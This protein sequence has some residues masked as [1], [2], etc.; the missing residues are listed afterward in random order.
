VELEYIFLQDQENRSRLSLESSDNVK[1]Y[2]AS[3]TNTADKE[4]E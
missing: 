3:E 2:S 1:K 4:I